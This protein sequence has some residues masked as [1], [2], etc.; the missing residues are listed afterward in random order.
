MISALIVSG[1]KGTRMGK[2]IPKQYLPLKDIPIIIRTIKKFD[3]IKDI[4]N[5]FIVLNE[6]Y[7]DFLKAYK[8]NKKI[9]IVFGG[10][11]RHDSV[12]NGLKE[13]KK[14]YDS[15]IVLIHD[16]VRPF[17]SEEIINKSIKF[18][19]NYKASAPGVTSKD[20]LKLIDEKG[21]STKSIDRNKIKMIQTPQTFYLDEIL[22]CHNKR[23]NEGFKVLDDTE[24]YEKYYGK[25]YIFD[26]SYDNI[27]IT[28]KDDLSYSNYKM[29][30]Y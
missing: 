27:K 22:D 13:I 14:I 29:L 11:E 1:G 26:G 17:V 19:K 4:D 21:F 23:H 18:T 20:S 2:D 12:R 8:F 16:G 25:V 3:L 5:I 6:E 24:L 9:H 30:E 15:D 28:T 10:K 7:K